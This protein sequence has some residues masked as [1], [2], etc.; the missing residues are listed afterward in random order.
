MGTHSIRLA[1]VVTV[2]AAAALAL[3]PAA[4][5]ATISPTYAV[6]GAEYSATSTEGKFAGFANGSAGDTAFWNAEVVH[7][8]LSSSC[9]SAPAGCAINSGGSIGLVTRG[10][11][12][13]AGFFTGGSI[14]LVRQSPG[15]GQQLF[16]VVGHLATSAGGAVFDVALTHYRVFLGSCVTVF[17]TVGPDPVDGVPGTLSF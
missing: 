16:H 4:A 10:G 17:A 13:V 15:C 3:L 12:V 2:L 8:P 14:T 1:A 7:Q 6:S 9:Y 5:G 11:D